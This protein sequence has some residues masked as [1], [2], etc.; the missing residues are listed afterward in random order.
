MDD[1]NEREHPAYSIYHY[2]KRYKTTEGVVRRRCKESLC[3]SSYSLSTGQQSLDY[4]LKT[5]SQTYSLYQEARTKRNESSIQTS[6][7]IHLCIENRGIISNNNSNQSSENEILSPPSKRL[8][9]QTIINTI[10]TSGNPSFEKS[11]A[12]CFAKHSLPLRLTESIE[13]RNMLTSFRNSTSDIPHRKLLSTLQS[14][15]AIEIRDNFL[16]N[17]L[18]NDQPISLALD[19]WTNVNHNKVTNILILSNCKPFFFQS[20]ENRYERTTADWMYHTLTP[21]IQQLLEKRIKLVGIVMDNAAVNRSLFDK[22]SATYPFLVHIPCSA[23]I[24]NLCIKKMLTLDGIV[25]I[26]EFM[27]SILEKF[28]GDLQLQLKLKKLQR[29]NVGGQGKEGKVYQLLRP[30]DTRWCSSLPAARRLL[31]LQKYINFIIEDISASMWTKVGELVGLLTVFESTLNVL[32]SDST[33][34]YNLYCAFVNLLDSLEQYKKTLS[35]IISSPIQDIIVRYWLKYVNESLVIMSAIFSFD[36][37]YK[38]YFSADKI[39]KAKEWY[40]KFA[41]KYLHFHHSNNISTALRGKLVQQFASFQSRSSYFQSLTSTLTDLADAGNG[42]LNPK[43][44]FVIFQD[45]A[46]ELC[47]SAIAVLSLPVSEASVERSFSHQGAIHTKKRNRLSEEQIYNEMII[48]CNNNS[49]SSNSNS[50]SPNLVEVDDEYNNNSP[51]FIPLFE[52]DD[53]DNINEEIALRENESDGE[54]NYINTAEIYTPLIQ[55]HNENSRYNDEIEETNS[56]DGTAIS[57]SSNTNTVIPKRR[58]TQRCG[59]EL[60]PDTLLA[61][62]L[63]YITENNLTK[64]VSWKEVSLAKLEIA[65]ASTSPPIKDTI[66]AV[67]KKINKEIKLQIQSQKADKEKE[68][69]VDDDSEIEEIDPKSLL[70]KPSEGQGIFATDKS[71]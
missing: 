47:T 3:T 30:C 67:T 54:S 20:I 5:H 64:A 70:N 21:Y 17:C 28:Q 9:Q 68:N 41:S 40:F 11:I 6:S 16:N 43:E 49:N 45:G 62:A 38:T 37:S 39:M 29:E 42:H 52:V 24:L 7:S 4:H 15:V 26:I 34:Q 61:F 59:Y 8:K 66:E 55:I 14:K 56:T 25:D 51:E 33:N 44:V 58:I 57:C 31:D 23:H 65:L 27:N 60:Q 46:F 22:L 19:S 2:Y 69:Q 63:K 1:I 71:N 36:Q 10:K 53:I 13:F 50:L 32:Q 18:Q 12:I 48:K 35:V